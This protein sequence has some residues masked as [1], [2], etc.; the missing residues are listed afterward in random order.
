MCHPMEEEVEGD[1]QLYSGFRQ[2]I[3]EKEDDYDSTA[4]FK[5]VPA[6]RKAE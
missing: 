1:K 4:A 2:S 6:N 3:E 5:I